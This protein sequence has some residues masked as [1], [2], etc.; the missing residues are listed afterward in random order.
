MTALGISVA[1]TLRRNRK[2]TTTTSTMV[3]S[4]VISTSRTEARM[5]W[6]R[7]ARM[8]TLIAGGMSASQAGQRLVDPVDGLDDVGA[9]LL[10]D[11]QQDRPGRRFSVCVG[12]GLARERPGADLVVLDALRS[13]PPMSLTRIGAPLW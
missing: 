9:G 3:I 2:I 7:S 6:V 8:L 11:D 1:R 12:V 10:E 5:V 4:R 13:T